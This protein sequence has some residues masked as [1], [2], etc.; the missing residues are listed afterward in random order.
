[1]ERRQIITRR[2]LDQRRVQIVHRAQIVHGTAV[3]VSIYSY[4]RAT[5]DADIE[6]AY[7]DGELKR[8]R[9]SLDEN[10]RLDTQMS[11]ETLTGSV[12]NILTHVP[13]KFDVELFRLGSDEH[14]Q[15]RF[16]RRRSV[17]LPELRIT[18]VLPAPEDVI[19][20]KLQRETE[21]G[22]Q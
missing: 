7:S 12:R 4:P 21:R 5:K 2:W 3:V 10:F 6:I 8:I 16:L 20:Q 1:M 19:I 22:I 17:V 13:T 15:E 14:H 11:F 18:A 9:R